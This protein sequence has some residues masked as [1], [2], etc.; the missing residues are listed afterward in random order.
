MFMPFGTLQHLSWTHSRVVQQSHDDQSSGDKD[1]PSGPVKTSYD[2]SS[3]LVNN[4]TWRRQISPLFSF[5][6]SSKRPDFHAGDVAEI[7]PPCLLEPWSCTSLR[8]RL[9]S[10]HGG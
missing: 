8:L 6:K 3:A 9:V 2:M 10:R 1:S 4:H 5:A 7:G